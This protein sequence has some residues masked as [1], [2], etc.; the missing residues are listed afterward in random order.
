MGPTS[1][2]GLGSPSSLS[3]LV[4]ALAALGAGVP[5]VGCSLNENGAGGDEPSGTPGSSVGPGT[6][7]AGGGTGGAGSVGPGAGAA[8]GMGGAGGGGGTGGMGG[9]GPVAIKEWDASTAVK[10]GLPPVYDLGGWM[11][12]ECPTD[13]RTS[14]DSVSTLIT[15][16]GANAARPRAVGKGPGLSVESKRTNKILHSDTW[17]AGVLPAVD[18]DPGWAKSSMAS[19]PVI[20]PAALSAATLFDSAGSQQSYYA[21][22]L[23]KGFASAWLKGGTGAMP[24]ARF[25]ADPDA[26]TNWDNPVDITE[27]GWRR[28]GIADASGYLRLETRGDGDMDPPPITQPSSITAF[29]AQLE[30]GVAYP[31]SYIPTQEAERTREADRLFVNAPAL[32]APGGYFHLKLTFSPNYATGE[33]KENEHDLFHIDSSNR[34]Y[35]RFSD[36]KIVLRIQGKDLDSLPLTWQREQE[37]AV[38][39]IHSPSGRRLIVSGAN[40]TDFSDTA[41]EAIQTNVPMYILGNTTGAQECADLRYIGF[42]PPN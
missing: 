13:K 38:E 12:I 2:L 10:I 4:L 8:G 3:F 28:Y 6:G 35:L 9:S 29:G 42:F 26:A 36:G 25:V 20:G 11:T 27:T 19:A 5:L 1:R 39:A 40:P 31:S 33:N 32:V 18:P 30:P 41:L 21:F 7:G 34:I 24:F 37:I 16:Y 14:Q 22:G 17:G 15:G 23:P